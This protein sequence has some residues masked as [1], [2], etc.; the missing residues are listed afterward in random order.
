M[1]H[2]PATG[3]SDLVDT[4]NDRNS[5]QLRNGTKQLAEDS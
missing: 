4:E 2:I 1:N 5:S 3:N